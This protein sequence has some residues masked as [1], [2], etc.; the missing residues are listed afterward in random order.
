LEL[1]TNQGEDRGR[2][3]E[4][5]VTFKKHFISHTHPSESPLLL[6]LQNHSSRIS[7]E[8]LD[9]GKKKLNKST[10][11]S[12]SLFTLLAALDVPVYRSSKARRENG[13]GTCFKSP[14]EKS[15]HV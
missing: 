9:I 10:V 6:V 3:E 7:C 8:V 12:C 1:G 15:Y 4:T 11:V 14:R 13:F 2:T 5:F